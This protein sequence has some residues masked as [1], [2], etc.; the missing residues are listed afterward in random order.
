[1]SNAVFS[2]L[3]KNAETASKEVMKTISAIVD[4]NSFVETDKF[5]CGDTDLGEAVGEGVVSGFAHISDIR[6]GLF[7]TNPAV[8][9]GSIGKANSKKI[10]KLIDASLRGGLPIVALLDTCG[11]RFSEGID[12]MEGYAAIYSALADAYGSVPTIVAV[13]GADFGLSSYFCAVSDLCVTYG[14]AQIATSSPLILAGG[15]KADPAKICNGKTLS[16]TCDV[17]T[18]V[19]ENEK[20]MKNV[21]STFLSYTVEPIVD[22][23]DDPNRT[24]KTASLKKIDGIIGEI[25]D[26]GSALFVRD[27]YSANVKTGFARLGGVSVG[28]VATD[29]KLTGGGAGKITELLNTCESFSMPVINIVNC[30]GVDTDIDNDGI[31]VRAV[32]D[33]MFTYNGLSVPKLALIYGDAIGIGYMAFAAKS[34]VDYSVAWA[35][36]KIGTVCGEVAARLLYGKEISE[37]KDKDKAAEKLAAAYSEEN[38]LAPVVAKKGYLDNV[39]EPSLSRPYLVAALQTYFDKE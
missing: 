13:K 29:G 20:E 27:A 5:I 33:M 11:A 38:L 25:F 15:T 34:N 6:V 1:M 3:T 35:D 32:S 37:A 39:I 21:V 9:K 16:R 31:T 22:S 23:A 4:E 28:F 10:V 18:N 19:V 8:L 14:N 2:K 36:A 30:D 24:A 26:K 12:A 7:A 17:I